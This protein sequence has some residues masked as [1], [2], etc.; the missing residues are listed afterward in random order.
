MQLL[1]DYLRQSVVQQRMVS[2]NAE[3]SYMGYDWAFA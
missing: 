1:R 3:H 2:N